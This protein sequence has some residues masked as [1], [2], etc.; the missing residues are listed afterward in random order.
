[1]NKDLELYARG[2]LLET[3][4]QLPEANQRI[5]KLMYGRDNGKRSMADAENL[6]MGAITESAA[7]R[8]QRICP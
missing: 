7:W 8:T 1:M 3:A 5:F 4:E 2:R 6:P